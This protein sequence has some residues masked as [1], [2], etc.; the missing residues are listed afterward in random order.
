MQA[1][2]DDQHIGAVE[3]RVD[4]LEKK[5]DDGFAEVRTEFRAVRGDIAGLNRTIM[6]MWL[7]MILG[8]AGIVLQQHL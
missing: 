5:V 4:K 8:F 1:L 2:S 7:T 6:A 3:A